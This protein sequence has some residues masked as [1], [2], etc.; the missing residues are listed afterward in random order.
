MQ[1]VDR[2]AHVQALPQPARYCGPRVQDPPLRL[3]PGAEDRDGIVEHLRR[4]RHLR[5]QPTVR[6]TKPK[7]AVRRAIELVALLVDGAVVVAAE[8]GEVRERGG[9]SLGP[10]ANVMALAEAPAAARAAAAAASMVA[11]PA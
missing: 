2:V 4:P 9:A 7:L 5:Q 1:D 10:V 3:V 8:Q 6:A 11:R